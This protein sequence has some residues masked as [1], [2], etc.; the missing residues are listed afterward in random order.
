V[1]NDAGIREQPLDSCRREP[2]HPC[3]VERGKGLAIGVTLVEDR[4]PAQPGLRALERQKLEQDAI[5]VNRNAPLSVV[6]RNAQRRTRPP[7]STTC[8]G[9]AHLTSY[10][11]ASA[12]PIGS[13]RR[14][15]IPMHGGAARANVRWRVRRRACRSWPP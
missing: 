6:I 3:G 14:R 4:F 10:R 5:V 13:R 8:F 15:S 9:S 12:A 7:T 2:R 1:A 11:T